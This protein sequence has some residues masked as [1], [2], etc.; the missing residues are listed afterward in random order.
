MALQSVSSARSTSNTIAGP[1]GI[2]YY[3]KTP[4]R[5]TEEFCRCPVT[6]GHDGSV[7]ADLI[8]NLF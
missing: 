7:I 5:K 1:T 8:G 3:D 6:A 2:K 4:P